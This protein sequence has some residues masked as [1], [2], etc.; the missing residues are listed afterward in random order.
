MPFSLRTLLNNLA[1]LHRVKGEPAREALC[2]RA[3]EARE[4]VPG[5]EHP[6]TLG[7][8]NNLAV[9]LK[10]KGRIWQGLKRPQG[11]SCSPHC[12]CRLFRK[13]Q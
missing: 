5:P 3:L 9:L 8:L 4:L 10:A 6:D 1:V 2:R 12:L 11:F 7:S 13:T